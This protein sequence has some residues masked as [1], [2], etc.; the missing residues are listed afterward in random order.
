MPV[1]I[2]RAFIVGSYRISTSSMKEAL[3]KGDYVLVNKC[4]TGKSP[5]KRND[6][7]IFRSPVAGDNE[8]APV[9]ISRCIAMPGDTIEIRDDGYI[10][11]GAQYP[12]SPTALQTYSVSEGIK[13]RFLNILKKLNIPQREMTDNTASFDIRL[14]HF[15]EYRIREEL[16]QS[17]NAAFS[18]HSGKPYIIITPKKGT[19]APVNKDIIAA[20]RE[21]IIKESGNKA[22]F[23]NDRLYINSEEAESFRFSTDYY[24][25]LSDNINEAIDSRHVGFIPRN[26]IIGKVWFRWRRAGSANSATE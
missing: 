6:I 15:E 16:S 14:T 13:S 21:A 12:R 18:R 19:V 2:V 20:C 17:M 9:L 7:I 23:R 5:V 25:V 22:I 24:W 8:D 26:M 1:V 10:I 11:N 4:L 3:Q